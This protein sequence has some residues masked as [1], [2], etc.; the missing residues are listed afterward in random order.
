MTKPAQ[1][2]FVA[3]HKKYKKSLERYRAANAAVE[4]AYN[5]YYAIHQRIMPDTAQCKEMRRLFRL[6][7]K[8]WEEMFKSIFDI[9]EHI[10]E[11]A[12]D[13]AHLVEILEAMAV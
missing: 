10:R 12:R 6:K 5:E 1:Y 7:D 13:D 2:K 3:L 9:P 8:H 4:Q 11:S